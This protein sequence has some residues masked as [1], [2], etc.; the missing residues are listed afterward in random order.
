MAKWTPPPVVGNNE[1][2]GRR[3]FDEPMLAGAKEQPSFQGLLL[4][5]FEETR[6]DEY[7]LDRLGNSGIDRR[8]VGYLRPRADAAGKTSRKPKRFDGWAAL[9]AQELV[10]ARKPPTL[11]VISSPVVAPDPNDN[12]YHAHVCRPAATTPHL[13]ALHLRHLFSAYGNVERI[14]RRQLPQS[15]AWLLKIPFVGSLLNKLN[16]MR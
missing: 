16:I 2:V 13:M 9:R 8:V 14:R 7:S 5:H 15:L 11:S 4:S 6:G 1:H 10:Q 3:L 12:I